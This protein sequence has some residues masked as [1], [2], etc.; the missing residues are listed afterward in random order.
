MSL[1]PPPPTGPSVGPTPPR[2]RWTR[3]SLRTEPSK[4]TSHNLVAPPSVFPV[5]GGGSCHLSP[6]DGRWP[7]SLERKTAQFRIS[8]G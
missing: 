7:L 6:G 5:W 4:C 2:P 8:P 3:N 1:T